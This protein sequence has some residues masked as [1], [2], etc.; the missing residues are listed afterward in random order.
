MLTDF[1]DR[2]EDIA[3]LQAVADALAEGRGAAL[4]VEG[5]SGIG[6]SSL[7]A[8]FARQIAQQPGRLG[9][10]VV[11]VRCLPGIGA[12]LAY[13]PVVDILLSLRERAPASRRCG[14][15][16]CSEPRAAAPRGR[17]PRC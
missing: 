12:G 8:H 1:V 11:L 15:A 2:V 4:L 14:C 7:L 9:P 3:E 5:L 6:K 13:G 10:R 16:V 17:R